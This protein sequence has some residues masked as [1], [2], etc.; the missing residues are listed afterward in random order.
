MDDPLLEY[1]PYSE[2]TADQDEPEHWELV[3]GALQLVEGGKHYGHLE[4][5]VE[6]LRDGARVTMVPVY[7]F[8]V[9]DADYNLERTER[10]EYGDELVLEL[11]TDGQVRN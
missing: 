7:V 11:D 1:N 3:D 10:R 6:R 9:L 8:P 2:W 5:D 4:V